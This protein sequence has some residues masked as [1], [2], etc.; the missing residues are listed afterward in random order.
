[1]NYVLD[2][3]LICI[4]KTSAWE[5]ENEMCSIQSE[6][7]TSLW[8]KISASEQKKEVPTGTGK[9]QT[10][11][12]FG[13]A[14]T[15]LLVSEECPHKKEFEEVDKYFLSLHHFLFFSPIT[16]NYSQLG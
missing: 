15:S 3:F 10:P 14:R 6:E 8:G 16:A 2:L 1:M 11:K 5:P 7:D 4:E 13:T 12:E 9:I